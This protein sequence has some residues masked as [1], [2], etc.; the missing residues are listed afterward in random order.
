MTNTSNFTSKIILIACAIFILVMLIIQFNKKSSVGNISAESYQNTNTQENY[1]NIQDTRDG[2]N[3]QQQP[4]NV[5][6]IETTKPQEKKES[7]QNTVQAS[8]PSSNEDYK[9][10]D[11]ETSKQSPTECYPR[12]KLTAEDLL[13]KDAA[14]SKWAEVN[15]A[16][17]GDVAD[18]NFLSAGHHLGVDTI[19]QSL[20]NPNYQ[21]RSDPPNPK[22][23]V[24]PWNQSTI[25]FDQGRKHFEINEC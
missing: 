5:Q 16:G 25:E 24:G 9:A 10:I 12:D 14:N 7:R 1:E 18:R 3:T 4:N 6:P 11:Y 15:P 8:E 22:L 17:Q 20:R 13:P 2:N 21:L 23:T 19:G